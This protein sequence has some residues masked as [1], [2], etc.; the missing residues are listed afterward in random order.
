M[1]TE[2][3]NEEMTRSR[4]TFALAVCCNKD[5]FE[6]RIARNILNGRLD[7]RLTGEETPHTFQIE[8]EGTTPRRDI[9][10]PLMDL[11]RSNLPTNRD[12][13][14][15]SVNRCQRRIRNQVELLR[16]GV[17]EFIAAAKEAGHD[18]FGLCQDPELRRAA[19]PEILS[20]EESC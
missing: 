20:V 19:E 16:H 17:T 14:W 7:A 15:L 13:S 6:K 10:Y 3:L 18:S 4:L 12:R 9:M 2:I 1:D 11:I 8:Y 5:Q